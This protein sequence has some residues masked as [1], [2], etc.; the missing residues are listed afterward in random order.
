MG[1]RSQLRKY[2]NHGYRPPIT[3]IS[4]NT[5]TIAA[6][7]VAGRTVTTLSI[8]GGVAPAT[9]TIANAGGLSL[10]ISGNLLLTN[11]NPVGAVGPAT[12]NIKATDGRGQT[13]TE[14]IAVTVT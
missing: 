4:P 10:A 11:A 12:V 9:Y 7:G 5:A 2:E 1:R 8:A 3:G 6:A 13:L 14:P